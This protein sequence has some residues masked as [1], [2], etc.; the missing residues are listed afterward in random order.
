MIPGLYQNVE[1]TGFSL[2]RSHNF[3]VRLLLA[4]CSYILKQWQK[5]FFYLLESELPHSVQERMHQSKGQTT[6]LYQLLLIHK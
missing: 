6:H 2:S 1:S 3:V 4:F 5:M